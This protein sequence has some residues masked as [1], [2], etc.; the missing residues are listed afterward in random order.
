MPAA[1]K[2]KI[3]QMVASPDAGGAEMFA[4]RLLVALARHPA[5]EQQVVVRQ[6]SWLA[7]ELGRAGVVV[8]Q[9]AFGGW[10]DGF[11]GLT[12][13]RVQRIA[14][15]FAPDVVQSWMNRATRDVPR[16]AWARVGRLGG[17]YK[18][19]NYMNKVD[20][21][22]GNTEQIREYCVRGGWLRE[23]V[24]YLPNFVPEPLKGWRDAASEVRRELGITPQQRVLLQ[25]GRLHKVKGGDVAL[26][27]LQKLPAEVVL[28]FAGE[29][30]E[31]EVW[32]NMAQ[33][34]G[35]AERVRFVGWTNTIA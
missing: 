26:R 22:I 2:L 12:R 3:L 30:P 31:R 4:L 7:G 15:E 1:R 32:Q 27:A 25:A 21:I 33:K 16:G 13:R 28:V 19:K 5:I 23:K 11:L 24:K 8:H 29:G 34:L 6:G 18:L 35:V 9:V 20:Y 14:D 17:F 10:L